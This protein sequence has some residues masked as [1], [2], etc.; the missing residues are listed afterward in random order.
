MVFRYSGERPLPSQQNLRGRWPAEPAEVR[1]PWA[2]LL[3]VPLRWAQ[4]LDQAT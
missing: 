1:W 2:A 3:A 4:D